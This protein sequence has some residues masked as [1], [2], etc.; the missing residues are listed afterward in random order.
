MSDNPFYAGTYDGRAC[1]H[2]AADDRIR[3]VQNFNAEQC[4]KALETPNLQSTVR[5]AIER[6]LRKL[7]KTG[8]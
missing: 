7:G 4:A 8:H 5:K 2:I 3:A 6:Q 1:F